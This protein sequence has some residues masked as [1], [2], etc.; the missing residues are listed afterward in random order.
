M[1]NREQL[2]QELDAVDEMT[3]NIL[4]HVIMALKQNAPIPNNQDNWLTNNPLKNS[5]LDEK[6]IVSSINED[7]DVDS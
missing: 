1:I 6:D 2:K 3:I 4:H 7:W 5:V